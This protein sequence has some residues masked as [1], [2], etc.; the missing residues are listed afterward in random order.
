[1]FPMLE[2]I[3]MFLVVSNLR[4]VTDTYRLRF[5]SVYAILIRCPNHAKIQNQQPS[6]WRRLRLRASVRDAE[7]LLRVRARNKL[8]GGADSL[9][10]QYGSL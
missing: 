8:I 9:K 7:S 6:L 5:I 2:I 3:P 4:I 1:M 10:T